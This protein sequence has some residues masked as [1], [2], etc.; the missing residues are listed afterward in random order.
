MLGRMRT[1]LAERGVLTDL[2]A[3]PAP[4]G[5]R[6]VLVAGRGPV[7]DTLATLLGD[8]VRIGE[9][10][11]GERAAGE[12]DILVSCAGW[13]PDYDWLEI[14][15]WCL[16]NGMPWHR[17]RWVRRR[18][19]RCERQRG[20]RSDRPNRPRHGRTGRYDRP[21]NRAPCLRPWAPDLPRS[22]RPQR[23]SRKH[24]PAA[25]EGESLSSATTV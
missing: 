4:V 5:D 11:H 20:R 19:G 6:R 12:F 17:C 3:G 10:P 14:D 21:R 15:D 1:A 13:L 7:A 2:P 18:L 25:L 22:G 8:A 9:E 16:R 24:Q 23:S